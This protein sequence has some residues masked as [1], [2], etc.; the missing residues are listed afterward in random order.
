MDECQIYV[1]IMFD[2][3]VLTQLDRIRT[4][5]AFRVNITK[6]QYENLTARVRGTKGQFTATELRIRFRF[7]RH[8]CSMCVSLSSIFL[9]KLKAL[10]VRSETKANLKIIKITNTLC[11]R[12]SSDLTSCKNLRAR[13]TLLFSF[14]LWSPGPTLPRQ[15]ICS[16]LLGVEL[17]ER[18]RVGTIALRSAFPLDGDCTLVLAEPSGRGA[19]SGQYSIC[20]STVG[21][22]EVGEAGS[23]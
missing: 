6:H 11:C 3:L 22:G 19:E 7:F 5:N 12:K 23:G 20:I 13:E 2:Q 14:P 1:L 9:H 15:H 8:L 10:K 16:C 4:G 17:G 18:Q 21:L